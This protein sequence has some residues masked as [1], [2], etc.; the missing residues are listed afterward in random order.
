[1]RAAH[2]FCGLGCVL[3]L[4]VIHGFNLRGS[5]GCAQPGFSIFV[6]KLVVWFQAGSGS[7]E[8]RNYKEYAH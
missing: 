8:T 6:Q 3:Y 5:T 1:M 4:E 7:D 2:G